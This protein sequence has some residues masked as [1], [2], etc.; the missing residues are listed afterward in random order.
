MDVGSE[1]VQ[2]LLERCRGYDRLMFGEAYHSREERCS[3]QYFV[4]P[5]SSELPLV[6]LI[7][8]WMAELL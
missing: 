7:Y 2:R 5:C 3:Y 4:V 6:M 1:G 8:S